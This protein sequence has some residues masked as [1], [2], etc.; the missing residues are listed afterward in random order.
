MHLLEHVIKE[1][2]TSVKSMPQPSNGIEMFGKDCKLCRT[3][4]FPVLEQ[5]GG[6][7]AVLFLEFQRDKHDGKMYDDRLVT[8][9]PRRDSM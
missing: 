3:L 7:V 6:D 4:V 5:E 1:F 9:A 2:R 8:S